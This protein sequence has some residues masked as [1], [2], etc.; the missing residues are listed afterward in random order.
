MDN[1]LEYTDFLNEKFSTT[2]VDREYMSSISTIS[3]GIENITI[4]IGPDPNSSDKI[5]KVSNAL[6]DK[7]GQ[8]C[9]TMRISNLQT[10]GYINKNVITDEIMLKIK[11]FITKNKN[12]IYDF[13]DNYESYTLKNLIKNLIK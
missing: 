4:W 8:N 10:Y 3:H 5:I 9:F 11:T 6:N 7:K 13:Y 2:E 1:I 12:V